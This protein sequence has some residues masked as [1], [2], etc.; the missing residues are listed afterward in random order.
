MFS[1]VRVYSV[2]KGLMRDGES[3]EESRGQSITSY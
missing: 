2:K 1:N 3:R